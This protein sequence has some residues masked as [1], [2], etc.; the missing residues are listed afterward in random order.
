MLSYIV[1]RV[2]ASVP[3]LLLVSLAV[4]LLLHLA[5]G[6]PTVLVTGQRVS[7][8]VY[9]ATRERLG[10][11][12][13]LPVQYWRFVRSTAQGDLGR[14]LLYRRPTTE[15]LLERLPNT[16]LLS[17]LALVLCY[18]IALPTGVVAAVKRGSFVDLGVMT[19]TTLGITIPSFWLGLILIVLFAVKLG[20]FPASGHDEGLR[21][22]VL[23]VVTLAVG[24][25]AVVAR[26]VR[27]SMIESLSGDYVRTA[28]AKGLRET[29]VVVGHALRNALLPTL[30]VLGLQLGFL[31]VST[32]VVESVFGW[33]G[34]GRLLVDSIGQR[35]FPVVQGIL[36]VLGVTIVIGNLIADVLYRFAD[37][38]LRYA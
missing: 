17:S 8:E 32:V 36:L 7:A 29:R 9:A 6:D 38:K 18:L 19:W 34:V 14:S 28:R 35:D 30:S 22:V 31:M 37:P 15:L 20:W 21:S 25:A 23:P 2:L 12:E 24:E 4:F 13:P 16:L 1:R 11:D 26:F 10:L 33:P 3:A 5:P 27:S